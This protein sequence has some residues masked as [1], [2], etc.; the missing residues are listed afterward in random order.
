MSSSSASSCTTVCASPPP[1]I[2]SLILKTFVAFISAAFAF[3]V[4]LAINEALKKTVDLLLPPEKVKE[5]VGIQWGI[6][7][8]LLVIGVGVIVGLSVALQ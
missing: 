5:S 1:T 2:E 7:I 6:A 4:A 3:V 8:L